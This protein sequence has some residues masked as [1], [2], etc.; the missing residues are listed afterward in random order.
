MDIAPA[1]SPAMPLSSTTL[2]ATPGRRHAHHQGE[3]ADQAVVRAE[4]GGAERACQA[5]AAAG[6]K[7]ADHF[8]VDLLVG[9]H[10]LGGVGVLGVGGAAFGALG[11]GEDEDRTEV[12]GQE[13]QQLAAEGGRTRFACMLTQK[14]EPVFLVPAL[15]FGECKQDVPLFALPVLR[16]VPVDGGLGAFVGEVLA[17]A[18]D[19]RRR[20]LCLIPGWGVVMVGMGVL[21]HENSWAGR[22]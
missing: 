21:R 18:A 1:R 7:P 20:G 11:Q 4:D 2:L 19:I 3:V 22:A 10:G 5:V 17:P 14:A 16:E 13:T 6:G 15:C 9:R 8:L 12:P